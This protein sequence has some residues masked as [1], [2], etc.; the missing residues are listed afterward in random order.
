MR[1][2]GFAAV[3]A[4][5]V[6]LSAAPVSAQTAPADWGDFVALS[7]YD[8][9]GCGGSNFATCMSVDVY[10]NATTNAVGIIMTNDGGPGTFTRI[11]VVNLGGTVVAAGSY[12]SGPDGAFEPEANQGLSGDGLEEGIWAWTAKQPMRIG[13]APGESG[14]F[15]FV[16]TDGPAL[17]EIGFAVQAQGFNDCSTKFGYWFENGAVVTNDNGPNGYDSNCTGTSV[18]EPSSMALLATGLAG[19]AFV[20]R[21][22]R[23][24][25]ELVD[26]DGNDIA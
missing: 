13:L 11:G 17:G 25:A 1:K 9:T 18:P 4:L 5:L 14:Y 12:S 21:R 26:E 7:Q 23:T 10:F 19:L 2:L 3:P 6:A 8:F 15:T 20:G 24:G 22:R 16:F